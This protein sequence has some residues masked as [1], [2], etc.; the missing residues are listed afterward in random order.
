M[1]KSAIF[2]LLFI[3]VVA[4]VKAEPVLILQQEKFQPGETLIG[5]IKVEAGEFAGQ[6]LESNIKFSEGRRDAFFDY[7]LFSYNNSYYLYVYLSRSGTFNLTISGILYKDAEDQL[8]SYTIKKTLEVS[9]ISPPNSSN[10]QILSIRPGVI[11]NSK[12]AQ[13]I[14]L[15]NKGNQEFNIT[16]GLDL[17]KKIQRTMYPSR[18]EKIIFTN[19]KSLSKF[20][21]DAYTIFSVPVI[22]TGLIQIQT[23]KSN[24]TNLKADHLI[25]QIKAKQNSEVQEKLELFNFADNLILDLELK[26]SLSIITIK[27]YPNQI[28]GGGSLSINF[29]VLSTSQGFFKDNITITFKEDNL[30]GLI[31]IPIEIY[32][33]SE[34]TS[35]TAVNLTTSS[36]SPTCTQKSGILCMGKCSGNI[37]FASDGPC[38][39]GGECSSADTG[40]GSGETNISWGWIIGIL[41][42]VGLGVGGY[43]L[44]QKVKSTKPKPAES[45]MAEKSKLFEKR[46]SGGLARG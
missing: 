34:N 19:N 2:L 15:E 8:K 43:F 4:L 7:E 28:S 42:L 14:I 40:L 24:K 21:I 25:F 20:I 1:K 9:A 39:I 41:I 22:N 44:Y 45:I 5:E 38:C 17:D 13:E 27:N 18:P 3:M 33:F 11:F 31:I 30:S 32:V 12:T 26:K 23:P 29:S 36:E 46:V 16:Y 35:L 6:I 37:D 10:T